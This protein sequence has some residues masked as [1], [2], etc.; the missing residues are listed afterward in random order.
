M[1]CHTCDHYRRQVLHVGEPDDW[2]W[3]CQNS[4]ISVD[5]ATRLGS[6]MTCGEMRGCKFHS[7]H[8]ARERARFLEKRQ[9]RLF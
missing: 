7:T 5:D 4:N 9:G 2:R 3:S 6:L 1:D 8:A